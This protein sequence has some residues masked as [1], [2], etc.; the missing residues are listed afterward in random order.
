MRERVDGAKSCIETVYSCQSQK[1][2]NIGSLTLEDLAR[3]H[4]CAP[5]PPTLLTRAPATLAA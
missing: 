5:P 3:L 4:G 2:K 1:K